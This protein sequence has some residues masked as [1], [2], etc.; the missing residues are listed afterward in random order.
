M[1]SIFSVWPYDEEGLLGKKVADQVNA[2]LAIYGPR[3]TAI[4]YNEE[5]NLVQELTMI[6][7]QWMLS[8]LKCTINEKTNI[9]SPGNIKAATENE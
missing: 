5:V 9:F 2:V 8:H 4:F 6:E 1:G 7:G 3:T